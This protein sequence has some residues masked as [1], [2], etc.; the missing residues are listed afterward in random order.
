MDESC[1]HL[2]VSVSLIMFNF[3]CCIKIQQQF[4][5]SQSVAGSKPKHITMTIC[6][7]QK[8]NCFESEIIIFVSRF[9]TV[10]KLSNL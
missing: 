10:L 9:P 8:F 7:K 6:F 3:C 5:F 2:H 4:K 1:F